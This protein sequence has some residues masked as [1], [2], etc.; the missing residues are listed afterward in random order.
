[1]RVLDWYDFAETGCPEKTAMTIGVFDGVHRGHQILIKK[2]V[3]QGPN[4]TVVTFRQSPKR[5]IRPEIAGG[6]ILSL[7]QKLEIFAGLGVSQTILIDFSEN[8]S[9][10]KGQEFIDLL[11]SRGKLSYLVV[12][13]NFRC[14]Y[15]L[16][17]DALGIKQLNDAR[18][19]ETE[20]VLRVLEGACPVS[21]SRIRKAIAVGDLATAG[22][23]LGRNVAL[24]LRG[25]VPEQGE[26]GLWFDAASQGRIVPPEGRYPVVVYE[27]D[28]IEGKKAEIRIEQGKIGIP[29]T[30]NAVRGIE[31]L[32]GSQGV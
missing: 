9:R 24:D 25:I 7:E 4:P 14:G 1:M 21:S 32:N 17:T 23:A 11:I 12:G 5:V 13:S 8:F 27:M 29:S 16:D 10:L 22:A 15:Q 19:V 26:G 6:T 3:Q 18:G 20:V 2:I 28:I 31:F 30:F